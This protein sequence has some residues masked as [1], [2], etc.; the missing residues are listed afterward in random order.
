GPVLPAG[1]GH[2]PA[3]RAQHPPPARAGGKPVIRSFVRILFAALALCGAHA[4]ASDAPVVD[5]PAGTL[6]GEA[7]AGVNAFR[8]IPYAQPPVGHLRWRAPVPAERWDGVRD[9]T[10]FGPAC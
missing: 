1:G 10:R 7:L 6:R 3:A 8:G 2:V 5:A 4:V 9:A